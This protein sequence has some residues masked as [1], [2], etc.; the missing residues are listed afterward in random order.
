MKIK[1]VAEVFQCPWGSFEFEVNATI[2][3]SG[4]ETSTD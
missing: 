3:N 1:V 4:L 2:D